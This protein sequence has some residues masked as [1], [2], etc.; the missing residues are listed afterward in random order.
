MKDNWHDK[1]FVKDWDTGISRTHPTRAEQ[2]DILSSVIATEYNGGDFIADIGSGSGQVE[3]IIFNKIPTANIVG[4][5]SSAEM[6]SV[7]KERLEKYGSKFQVV[8]KNVPDLEISDLP[9]EKYQFAIS[10][11]TLHEITNEQKEILF[12]KIYE[13][14]EKGGQFLIMDRI[15]VDL[16][17]FSNSY[18]GVWK[19]LEEK[20]IWNSAGSYQEYQKAIRDKQ[21]T[22]ASL[23]EYLGLLEKSGFAST[24]LHLH[25][26]RAL[27]VG[28]KE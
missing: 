10:V 28:I 1:G 21:D 2:L 20:F 8:L 27:I 7:A 6:I 11:Q 18:S 19:R 26:D 25:F 24:V 4:V 12:K 9:K 16:E 13:L 17:K 23:V 15:K 22:P 5:D 14:L 3:E